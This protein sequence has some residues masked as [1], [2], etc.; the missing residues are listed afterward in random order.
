M[1]KAMQ[2]AGEIFDDTCKPEAEPKV[3]SRKCVY[4]SLGGEV[5]LAVGSGRA[6]D[7][8]EQRAEEILQYPL[9]I[10]R[11]CEGQEPRQ[12]T[13]ALTILRWQHCYLP[14]LNRSAQVQI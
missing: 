11:A 5:G 6:P 10:L 3:E 7:G 8:L 9:R 12:V 14:V 1:R 13:R 2:S 4:R